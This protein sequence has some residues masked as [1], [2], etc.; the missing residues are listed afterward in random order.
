MAT[1][2]EAR[3]HIKLFRARRGIAENDFNIEGNIN[4]RDISQSLKMF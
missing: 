4:L 3:E 1:R 2:E